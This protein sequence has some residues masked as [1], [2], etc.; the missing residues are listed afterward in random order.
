[1][2][3][4]MMAAEVISA[5]FAVSVWLG[6]LK[7]SGVVSCAAVVVVKMSFLSPTVSVVS[8]AVEKLA[9]EVCRTQTVCVLLMLPA[10]VVKP[11]GR[12][13]ML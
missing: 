10:A 11:P 7:A 1:M 6:K 3:F 13:E 2:P 9:E 5:L 4:T 12:Q 8:T